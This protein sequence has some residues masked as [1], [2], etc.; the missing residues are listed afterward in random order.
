LLL[1]DELGYV[2]IDPR[3][4]ELLFQVITERDEKASI[5][6]AGTACA[7]G[8]LGQPFDIHEAQQQQRPES[9]GLPWFRG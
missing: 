3:G 4:A 1:L 8:S 6:T 7:I 2:R 5:A 9:P